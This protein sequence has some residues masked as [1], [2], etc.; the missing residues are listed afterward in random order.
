MDF[1]NNL[2]EFIANVGATI[3][4]SSSSAWELSTIDVPS[5]LTITAENQID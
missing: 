1:K 3:S 5:A 4:A 2:A